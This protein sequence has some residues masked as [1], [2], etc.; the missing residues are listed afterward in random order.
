MTKLIAI[1]VVNLVTPKVAAKLNLE[2]NKLLSQS[3][4]SEIAIREKK[5]GM[6]R[7]RTG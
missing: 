1:A 7:D 2:L 3:G 6:E 5:N 4:M